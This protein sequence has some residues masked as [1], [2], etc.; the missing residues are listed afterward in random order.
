MPQYEIK[1]VLTDFDYQ[2]STLRCQYK[3]IPFFH[4]KM[5]HWMWR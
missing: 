4:F 5:I 3:P 2:D 1:M